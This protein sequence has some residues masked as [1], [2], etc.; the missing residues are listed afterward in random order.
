[1]IP[2]KMSIYVIFAIAISDF[3]M[4]KKHKSNS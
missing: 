4:M 2:R 3:A 1:M